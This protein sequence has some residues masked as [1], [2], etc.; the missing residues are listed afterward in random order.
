MVGPRGTGCG[1]KEMG[2]GYTR[3]V[4]WQQ[5]AA[6]QPFQDKDEKIKPN[7][8]ARAKDKLN[9]YILSLTVVFR[10][11]LCLPW[12]SSWLGTSTAS[13]CRSWQRCPELPAPLSLPF[14]PVT[15]SDS[16]VGW[17]ISCQNTRFQ[18]RDG[19]ACLFLP[20]ELW[21][22][23]NFCNCFCLLKSLYLC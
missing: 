13:F 19:A 11:F 15:G 9:L 3:S 4:C 18:A 14:H 8:K 7:E 23:A 6:E 10:P 16:H 22:Y 12:T 20:R 17:P 2:R 21:R 5:R 1:K